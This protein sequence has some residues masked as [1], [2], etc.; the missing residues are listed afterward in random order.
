M[1][2]LLTL[3]SRMLRDADDGIP[4]ITVMADGPV[5]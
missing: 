5:P 2:L 3:L 1:L 4:I